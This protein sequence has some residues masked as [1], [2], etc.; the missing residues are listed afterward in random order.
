MVGTAKGLLLGISFKS[1]A[2]GPEIG[3]GGGRRSCCCSTVVDIVFE[4]LEFFR[5]GG[6]LEAPL[7]PLELSWALLLVIRYDDDDSSFSLSRST[8][9]VER[10]RGPL[11]LLWWWLGKN[12][13]VLSMTK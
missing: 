3:G 10:L 6:D 2:T 8:P 5:L 4:C 12:R 13:D 1:S 7:Y 11:L 9:L